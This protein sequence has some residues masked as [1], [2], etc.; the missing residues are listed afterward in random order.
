M[1]GRHPRSRGGRDRHRRPDPQR[2]HHPRSRGGRHT[3]GT[4][5]GGVRTSETPL[6]P[7]RPRVRL[8]S[9]HSRGLSGANAH[10]VVRLPRGAPILKSHTIWECEAESQP[11][12][13]RPPRVQGRLR[14]PDEDIPGWRRLRSGATAPHRARRASLSPCEPCDLAPGAQPTAKT[15]R[16]LRQAAPQRV[17]LSV[18]VQPRGPGRARGGIGAGTGHWGGQIAHPNSW[19]PTP[20]RVSRPNTARRTRKGTVKR[21][22]PLREAR[23][24]GAPPRAR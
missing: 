22:G 5:P 13:N 10:S 18:R 7:L 19:F 23:A 20:I 9:R 12:T 11:W 3:V 16:R 2:R 15:T 4:C 1:P 17:R 8:F 24:T 14:L 6:S 21:W